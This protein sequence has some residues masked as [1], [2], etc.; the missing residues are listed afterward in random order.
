M[1]SNIVVILVVD[2]FDD[3][4]LT[5][6]GPVRSDKPAKRSIGQQ[7]LSIITY[8]LRS[9]FHHC[10][11][12][13]YMMYGGVLVDFTIRPNIYLLS[14]PRS[15]DGTGHML[16]I[17]DN[18]TGAIGRVARNA[19]SFAAVFIRNVVVIDANINLAAVVGNHAHVCCCFLINIVGVPVALLFFVIS[20]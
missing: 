2:A 15:T 12:D 17:R 7:T 11:V 9:C 16:N 4:Y 14:G 10:I 20:I 5:A 19:D 1:E 6:I 13:K 3:V 8:H 18:Q